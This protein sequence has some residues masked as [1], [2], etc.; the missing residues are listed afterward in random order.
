VAGILL[1]PSS[2][3]DAFGDAAL[4]V[5]FGY[6]LEFNVLGEGT[7]KGAVGLSA[8]TFGDVL[9]YYALDMFLYAKVIRVVNALTANAQVELAKLSKIDYMTVFQTL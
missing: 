8:V 7:M 1:H 4:L 3:P 6:L 5:V 9:A 2:A